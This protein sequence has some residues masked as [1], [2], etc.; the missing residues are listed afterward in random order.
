MQGNTAADPIQE[1][2]EETNE[3]ESARVVND[4]DPML[5]LAKDNYAKAYYPLAVMCFNRKDYGNAKQWAQKAINANVDSK[6]A[7]EHI[8]KVVSRINDELFARAT[9]LEDFKSPAD[10]GYKK[11]YTPLAELYFKMYDYDNA[12]LCAVKA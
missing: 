10:K 2:V 7:P 8:A 3:K 12:N 6:Q 1:T 4:F 9:A 11:A 5:T